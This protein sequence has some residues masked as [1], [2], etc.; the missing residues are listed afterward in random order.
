MQVRARVWAS[1][2]AMTVALT[3]CE[4]PEVTLGVACVDT[5]CTDLLI[6]PSTLAN[7]DTVAW[8]VDG[9]EGREEKEL[10][11]QVNALGR[12]RVIDVEGRFTIGSQRIVEQLQIVTIGLPSLEDNRLMMIV[13]TVTCDQPIAISTVGGC[14]QSNLPSL[15]EF[16]MS[17][18]GGG[19]LTVRYPGNPNGPA[20]VVPNNGLQGYA[21]S[22]VWFDDPPGNANPPQ[23][24]V[25]AGYQAPFNA[26]AYDPAS[27]PNFVNPPAAFEEHATFWLD[28]LL[29][30]PYSVSHT[31]GDGT[32]PVV[33]TEVLSFECDEATNL[34]NATLLPE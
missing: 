27:A 19:S 7:V 12:D 8:S 14:V 31:G 15:T 10:D 32:E 23:F 28:Q 29:T 18:I 3:G 33:I 2:A 22:A 1:M 4:S 24:D 34:V 30:L 5:S 26:V 11:L 25:V 13:P 9:E 16:T 21:G 20:G 17:Q 6:T